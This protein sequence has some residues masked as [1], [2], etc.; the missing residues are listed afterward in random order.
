MKRTKAQG[1]KRLFAGRSA[2][3]SGR[4]Y[5]NREIKAGLDADGRAYIDFKDEVT[6]ESF[7]SQADRFSGI[8]LSTK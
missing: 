2:V 1:I 8:K 5:L 4:K 7:L 3:L 6:A